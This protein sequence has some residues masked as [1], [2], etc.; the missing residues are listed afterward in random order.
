[1]DQFYQDLV[2]Q[3]WMAQHREKENAKYI[4][5]ILDAKQAIK[6]GESIA[7]S[8]IAFIDNLLDDTMKLSS[9]IKDN[10]DSFEKF[11]QMYS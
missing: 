6:A 4:S 3:L 10:F 1:M 5:R 2:T 7:D 11:M 9:I 8:D